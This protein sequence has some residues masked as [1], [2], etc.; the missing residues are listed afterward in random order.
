MKTKFS[1]FCV[2][3]VTGLLLFPSC[4]KIKK[5][6]GKGEKSKTTGWAY[7]DPENGGYEYN[8]GYDQQTGPGLKFIE[9]GTFIMGRTQ[10]DVMFDWNNVPRR[11]TVASFYIDETEVRN[12]DYRMYLDWTKRVYVSYP[13]VY[14]KALPDTLVWRRELAYNEPYVNN[15]LRHPAYAEYPVVGVSWEQAVAFCEWRTDRVNEQILVDKG[16]LN[17][18]PTQRDENNFNTEAYLAGQYEGAVRKNLKDLNPENEERR[19]RWTDGILLPKYRLPTEAEWEY[20]AYALIGNSKEERLGNRRIFPWDGHWVR[21]DSRKYR[22]R[23][24]ANFVRGRGD[25]MGTAGNLNDSGDLTVPVDSYWPNDYGLY[26]MA[27]NVNEWVA[28]VYR[29]LTTEDVAEFNPF[30]GNVFETAVRDEE[31]NLAEKDSL[32]RI[33]YRKQTDAELVGRTNYKTADNRNFRDG[34]VQSSIV[35]DYEWNNPEHEK[36]GTTRMYVQKRG[37]GGND[38]S[39]LIN[40]RSRVYKGG[41]WRDRS[42]W[43]NPSTRRFLDQ[44]KS[45]DDI[46]F[47]CA[48]IHVGN[49]KG[50]KV[51]R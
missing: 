5:L 29:P 19:V 46:G 24:M 33:R 50:L 36:I 32:G 44:G 27:G 13:E 1:I 48:M 3:I 47:R 15:Y 39:S 23:M 22:G 28:D 21:K 25:F 10:Q 34:D 9:G 45:T 49:G 31:G 2:V 17:H 18:D 42:F 40:D 11:V 4:S 6:M 41:S 37:P 43:L 20:A 51:K 30:R 8:N 7:N 38:Y 14:Q 26:C 35:S 16:I 12:I